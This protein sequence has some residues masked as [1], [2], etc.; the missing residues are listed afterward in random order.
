MV[1]QVVVVQ[2]KSGAQFEGVL[3]TGWWEPTGKA[4]GGILLLQVREVKGPDDLV[5]KKL[6][7][8]RLIP[9]DDLVSFS[10]PGPLDLYRTDEAQQLADV[11]AQ[12]GKAGEI[13]ADTEIEVAGRGALGMER[14]LVSA[15]A[16]LGDETALGGLEE[17]MGGRG[18]GGV[19]RG[20]DQFAVNERLGTRT[21]YSEELYTTKISDKKFSAAQMR[22]MHATGPQTLRA[23]GR[24]RPRRLLL[25]PLA[26]GAS[27]RLRPRRLLLP[28]LAL[29]A[30]GRL[31]P[32]R[33]LLTRPSPLVRTHARVVD[34]GGAAG[35]RDRV[36]GDDQRPRGRGARAEGAGGG[37]GWRHG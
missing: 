7:E 18:K 33:L 4:K 23:S 20:W 21:T 17:S 27:G 26:L 25:P 24:L 19:Q 2:D 31:R 30:S 28:P 35:A 22:G 11:A 14:D 6:E 5:G 29:G 13:L 1:G 34:R 3:S 9:R 10:V 36:E 37:D 16:W 15:S 32:R 12:R 8:E